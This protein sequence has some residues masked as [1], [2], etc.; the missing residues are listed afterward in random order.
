MGNTLNF[1][2]VTRLTHA[3]RADQSVSIIV[4]RCQ[5]AIS[6]S[7]AFTENKRAAKQ[8]GDARLSYSCAFVAKT[9]LCQLVHIRSPAATPAPLYILN[10]NLFSFTPLT[11]LAAFWGFWLRGSQAAVMRIDFHR[12]PAPSI[13]LAEPAQNYSSNR[14]ERVGN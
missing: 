3:A 12:L 7:A 10:L 2:H 13:G 11:T 8:N 5:T 14:S 9:N 6:N 4:L 1:C